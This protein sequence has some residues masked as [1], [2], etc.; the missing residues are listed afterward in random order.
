MN[1]TIN[2]K[3]LNEFKEGVL[4][5][6]HKEDSPL[7]QVLQEAQN[8]FGYIPIEVQELIGTHLHISPAR[9]SGVVSFYSMFSM[10]PQGKDSIGVCMGTA[11][12]VKGGERLLDRVS[13]QIGAQL[14]ETSSDGLYTL[15]PTRCVGA[16]SLAPVIMVNDEIH[17]KVT[18]DDIRKILDKAN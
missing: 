9:I 15:V 5:N 17:S 8:T 18:S 2:K 1:K 16:C 6:F 4:V 10:T 11:C 7:M 14:G 12:Y 3:E 13:E